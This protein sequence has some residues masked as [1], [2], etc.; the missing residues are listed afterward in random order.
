MVGGEYSELAQKQ[1]YERLSVSEQAVLDAINKVNKVLEGTP[2]KFEYKVHEST[3][4][5]IVKVINKDSNLV[6][7]EIPPEK[8]LDL[9]EKLQQLA[10]G[11]FIDEKR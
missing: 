6:I 7:R 5:L 8:I 3:G 4:E 1:K 10:R 11:A 2:Q 9:V